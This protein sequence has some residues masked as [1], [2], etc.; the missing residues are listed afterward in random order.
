VIAVTG[1]FSGVETMTA[2]VVVTLRVHDRSWFENYVS[3]VPSIIRRFGGKYIAIGTRVVMEEG[4]GT[5]PD[6]IAILSY[7]SLAHLRASLA[8]EEYA[9]YRASRLG[10][11]DTQIL[12]FEALQSAFHEIL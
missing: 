5:P 3:N 1:S 11:A 8:S 6:Q 12:A 9:P 10:K 4:E 2:Y 7:P